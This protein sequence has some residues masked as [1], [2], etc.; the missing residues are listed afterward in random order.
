MNSDLVDLAI[1]PSAHHLYQLEDSSRVLRKRREIE[2]ER[3]E[4]GRESKEE[5][6]DRKKNGKIGTSISIQ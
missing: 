5:K 4:G 2:R 3:E 6:E 1:R